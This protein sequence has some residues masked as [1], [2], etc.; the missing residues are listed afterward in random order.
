MT[1]ETVRQI[2]KEEITDLK[3]E[4]RR[5]SVLLEEQGSVLKGIGENIES[6]LGLPAK[7]EQMDGRLEKLET[8][9]GFIKDIVRDHETRLTTLETD[10]QAA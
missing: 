7:M 1:E 9:N 4:T 8:D 3:Q 2:I 10:H 6:L 5:N